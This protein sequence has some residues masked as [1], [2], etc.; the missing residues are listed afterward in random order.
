MGSHFMDHTMHNGIRAS[1]AHLL[2]KTVVDPFGR[3]CLLS[4]SFFLVAVQTHINKLFNFHTDNTRSA[5]IFLSDT[6]HCGSPA[7]LLTVG[8]D[9]PKRFEIERWDSPEICASRICE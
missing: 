1:K 7:V 8:L 9:T 2:D 6:G 5:K 3:V 4:Q